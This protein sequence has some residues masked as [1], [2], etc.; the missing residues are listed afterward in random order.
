MMRMSRRLLGAAAAAVD[1]AVRRTALT[2][3]G[4]KR[5]AQSLRH[6]VR[7]A[8]LHRLRDRYQRLGADD[9]FFREP[10]KIV[11]VQD[12]R[13]V[14]PGVIRVVDLHWPSDYATFLPEVQEQYG[15]FEENRTA[16]ARLILHQDPRPTT[17]L[18]HG[19]RCGI[20]R[21]RATASRT[22]FP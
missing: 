22:T 20:H 19:Y 10:R 14:R 13:L 5:H 6:E 1:L 3:T 4:G 8:L 7:I 21:L 15:R 17:I 2:R 12:V 18:I 16:T 9:S 11:P